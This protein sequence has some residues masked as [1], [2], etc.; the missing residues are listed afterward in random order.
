[1]ENGLPKHVRKKLIVD[2]QHEI[3]SH[4]IYSRI[5]N[6]TKNEENKRLLNKIARDELSHYEL[7]KKHTG[8]SVK[9][10]WIKI[11]Y[12]ST[13]ISIFGM[14]FGFKLM[15]RG[16]KAAQEVDYMEMDRWIPEIKDVM[17]DEEAHE[18]ELLNM[19][20]EESLKYVGSVVLGLNDALV[21]LTGALAGLTFALQNTSIIALSGLITGIA[22][23]FSMA[24]SEYLS[25]KADGESD[26]GRSAIYTGGA[27]IITVILLVLPYLIFSNYIVCLAFTLLISVVIIF[28]FNYYISVAKDLRFWRRF[29]EMAGISLGVAAFSFGIGVLI[30]VIFNVEI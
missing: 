17:K 1:M 29:G 18:H 8:K 7:L 13:L 30:R 22:A 2:Q 23:S 12:Y 10:N 3:D 6:K 14:T 4:H 5:S 16:E 24:A 15:E 26:A 21:E 11:F 19:I 20:N 27:Y 28:I 9:P 25:S